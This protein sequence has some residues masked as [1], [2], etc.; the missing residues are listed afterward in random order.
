MEESAAVGNDC[1]AFYFPPFN[2]RE[3]KTKKQ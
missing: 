2:Y 1:G 3:L